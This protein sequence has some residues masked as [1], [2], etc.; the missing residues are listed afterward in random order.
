MGMLLVPIFVGGIF[1]KYVIEAGNHEQEL[2]AAGRA[3][4]IF[5][6]LGIVAVFVS[7]LLFI[8]SKK[9]PQLK[10]DLPNKEKKA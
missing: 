3:E 7:I 1:T 4:Y 10:L 2:M 6:G 8:S 5:I 9:N